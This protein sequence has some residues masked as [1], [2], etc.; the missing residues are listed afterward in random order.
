[1]NNTEW[2]TATLLT[3]ILA[4]VCI[5]FVG[6]IFVQWQRINELKN[7][8]KT[9]AAEAEKS[10]KQVSDNQE[11][12]DKA[13]QTITKQKDAIIEMQQKEI[14]E[15]KRNPKQEAMLRRAVGI[16]ET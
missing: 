16:D 5:L 15:L 14:K 3:I 10:Q 12:D 6:I 8:L 1:M 2:D 11:N 7:D 4:P 9:T 13:L